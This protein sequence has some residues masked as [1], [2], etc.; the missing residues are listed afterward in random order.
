[1]RRWCENVGEEALRSSSVEVLQQELHSLQA[2]VDFI[3]LQLADTTGVRR[4]KQTGL[5]MTEEE[6]INWRGRTTA[7]LSYKK[8]AIARVERVIAEK[9]GPKPAAEK[10]TA[11]AAALVREL[12]EYQFD[13]SED[14]HLLGLISELKQEVL[15]P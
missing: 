15:I 4:N 6:I 12:D 11:L 9:L 5:P 14:D 3:N 1:M 13:P 10:I 7:A 2:D 8:T